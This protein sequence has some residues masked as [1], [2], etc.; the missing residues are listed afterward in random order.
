MQK[1]TSGR[2][3]MFDINIISAYSCALSALILIKLEMSKCYVAATLPGMWDRTV[4][5][6]S[7]GKTFSVTGWK[8]GWSIGP[9][10]L[11]RGLRMAHNINTSVCPTVLQV[12]FACIVSSFSSTL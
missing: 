6:G 1:G 8:L 5:I 7:A 11:I 2:N 10:H 3:Y 12:T 9:K 4:T